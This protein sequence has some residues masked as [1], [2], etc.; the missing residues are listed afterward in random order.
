MQDEVG[1]DPEV[2]SDCVTYG[3]RSTHIYRGQKADIWDGGHRIPLLVSW[4]DHVP[5]NARS[6]D[7]ICLTDIFATPADVL[8]EPLP[9]CAA[10]DSFSFFSLLRGPNS[11]EAARSTVIHHSL[12]GM[13]AVRNGRWKLIPELGSGGFTPPKSREPS[14]GE[15]PGQLY[16]M[17]ND[18]SEGENLYDEWPDVVSRLR[19]ILEKARDNDRTAP[20]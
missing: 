14:P 15:P 17:Q 18:P 19:N 3:H 13:F 2:V 20:Q 5:Q 1:P 6:D 4:P 9:R 11:G 16:D 12:S 8:D 10:E 7:L